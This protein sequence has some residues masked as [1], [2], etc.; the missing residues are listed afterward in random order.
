MLPELKHPPRMAA[1]FSLSAGNHPI[2]REDMQ[3]KR[4]SSFHHSGHSHFLM[5]RKSNQVEYTPSGYNLTEIKGGCDRGPIV[6]D[7]CAVC[8]MLIEMSQT[9]MLPPAA[10]V[11]PLI[12]SVFF[13]P[14][15]GSPGFLVE[16]LG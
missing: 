12:W 1:L 5:N 4:Y 15:P 14:L 7:Q 3:E 8:S 16:N 13:P 9:Y 2:L 11:F 10:I 6:P